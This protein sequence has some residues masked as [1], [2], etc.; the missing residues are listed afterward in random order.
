MGIFTTVGYFEY[1]QAAFT[2][3]YLLAPPIMVK[4]KHSGLFKCVQAAFTVGYLL[5]P[6]IMARVNR[7]PQFT[8]GR[9]RYRFKLIDGHKID[10]G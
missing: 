10:K 5:A 3:C 4:I 6:P 8:A 9:D 2:E 1:V 7:R